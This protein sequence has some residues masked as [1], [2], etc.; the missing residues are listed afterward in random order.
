M[1]PRLQPHVTRS[2]S[3]MPLAR[4]FIWGLVRPF[5]PPKTADKIQ[6]FGG[7]AGGDSP[8]PVKLGKIVSL[9]ALGEADRPRHAAL[10]QYALPG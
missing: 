4:S 6:L 10:A 3:P 7:S 1:S 5:L 2:V 9:Q 8:C